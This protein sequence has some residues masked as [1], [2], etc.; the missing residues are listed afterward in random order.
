M[1]VVS[2]LRGFNKGD[3]YR[4]AGGVSISNKGS[5]LVP[6][7]EGRCEG[8]MGG[9]LCVCVFERERL[10]DTETDT[11]TQSDRERERTNTK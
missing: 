10:T 5:V 9:S 3:V 7:T 4:D 2:H 6:V 11:G 8:A 1:L